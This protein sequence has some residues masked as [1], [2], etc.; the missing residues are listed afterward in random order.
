MLTKKQISETTTKHIKQQIYR[1]VYKIYKN[2]Y[3][4]T[5]NAYK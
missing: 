5:W 3:T 2:I 1:N 4:Q